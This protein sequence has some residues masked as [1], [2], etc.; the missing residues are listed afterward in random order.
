MDDETLLKMDE[1]TM[2]VIERAREMAGD[3][4]PKDVEEANSTVLWGLVSAGDLIPGWWTPQRDA[5][6]DKFWRGASHISSAIY[7]AQAKLCAIPWR[8]VARDPS[9]TRHVDQAEEMTYLLQYASEFGE[10][11]DAAKEKSTLDLLT[12]DNGMFY[13]ILGEGPKNGP[14][15]GR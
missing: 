9:V 12:Q 13:E 10:T 1:K 14:I 11:F 8:I 7:N 3:P 15:V 2:A 6:L 5:A 4:V